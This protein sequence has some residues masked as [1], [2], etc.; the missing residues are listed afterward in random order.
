MRTVTV[1]EFQFIERGQDGPFTDLTHNQLPPACFDRL[2]ELLTETAE[3][4]KEDKVFRVRNRKQPKGLCIQAMSQVGY[5]QISDDSAV[6]ILPKIDLSTVSN[7]GAR[8]EALRKLLIKM[9]ATVYNLPIQEN[10]ANLGQAKGP[11][12]DIFIQ[13]FLHEVELLCRRGLRADYLDVEQN[14]PFLKGR[15]LVKENIRQNTLRLEQFYCRYQ[16]FTEDRI[17]NRLILSALLKV[18]AL[19]R[20]PNNSRKAV[21]LLSF[22]GQVSESRDY[23]QD[24]AKWQTDFAMRGYRNLKFW[25]K[26]LLNISPQLSAGNLHMQSILF[27]MEQ[28]FEAYIQAKFKQQFQIEVSR[29]NTGRFYRIANNHDGGQGGYRLARW[30]DD[31]SNRP[32]VF[33]LRPDI[34][35]FED[36]KPS[37][38]LDAKW[39][40]LDEEKYKLDIKESDVYQMLAYAYRLK[41]SSENLCLVFP[42]TSKFSKLVRFNFLQDEDEH[43]KYT[44]NVIPYDLERDVFIDISWRKLVVLFS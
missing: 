27:P 5:I 35:V 18:A 13:I 15:L 36:N 42:K 14:E 21:G 25:C 7:E 32:E 39:K 11:L 20:D 34:V 12:L 30:C 44:V 4:T 28:L 26:L 31:S 29:N 3:E 43:T 17:E 33:A 2:L 23:A 38:I 6:E 41:P 24:L 16:I 1:T 40:V 22:F 9:L 37:L 10:W 19:S 8:E